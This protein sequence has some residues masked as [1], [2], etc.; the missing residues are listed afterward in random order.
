MYRPPK[1]CQFKLIINPEKQVFRLYV[2]V[3]N[4]PSMT[5]FKGVTKLVHILKIELAKKENKP[6]QP[7][8]R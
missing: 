8:F 4:L 2:A 1:V 7:F 6:L 3:D 5:I